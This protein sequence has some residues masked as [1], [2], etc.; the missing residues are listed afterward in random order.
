M[1]RCH[2]QEMTQKYD[3]VLVSRPAIF[4]CKKCCD[5]PIGSLP[6]GIVLVKNLVE[7]AQQKVFLWLIKDG[8]YDENSAIHQDGV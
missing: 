2:E 3:L 6:S 8:I 1:P 4:R 5:W 7:I